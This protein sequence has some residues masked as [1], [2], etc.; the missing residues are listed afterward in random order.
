MRNLFAAME[1]RANDYSSGIRK[2]LRGQVIGQIGCFMRGGTCVA[3]LCASTAGVREG[4]MGATARSLSGG[5][6][7]SVSAAAQKIRHV[8]A[9]A[10]SAHH[11]EKVLV[12][13]WRQ[14]FF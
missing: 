2:S 11:V 6:L 1:L 7:R 5:H 13:K 12:R 10:A 8:R 4:H 9:Y 3:L 14:A